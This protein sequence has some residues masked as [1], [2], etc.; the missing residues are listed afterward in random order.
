M[1]VLWARIPHFFNSPYYVYQYATCFA[2]SSVFYD[3][4]T[5]E[6]YSKKEREEALTKYLNLLKSGGND[7]PMNQLKKAGVDLSK[8]ETV[9]AVTVDLDKLLDKLEVEIEK[10]KNN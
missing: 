3:R 5:S 1:E 7:N 8:R 9:E 10:L 4:I 6:N 2:S